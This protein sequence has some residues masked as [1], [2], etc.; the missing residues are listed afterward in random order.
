MKIFVDTAS[1]DE[2]K[3]AASWGVLD[4]VTTNPSLVAK[5]GVDFK[6]RVL[7]I[8]DIVDGPVSAEVTEL[9]ADKM[10]SQGHEI[11]E[12]H[13][14]IVVKIPLIKEGL[15]AI[16]ALSDDGI[17]VNVTL[18]FSVNQALLAAK[19]GATFVSVF[20]GRVDDIGGTGMD[21]ISDCVE[22]FNIYGFES[23]VLAASLRHPLHI[24]QAAMAGADIVTVP[25]KVLNG[26]FDHPLTDSGNERFLA[27]WKKAQE[28]M[29]SPKE[30]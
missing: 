20:V 12:W 1:L 14:N 17:K 8:C 25:Y 22:V 15:K 6:K 3:E 21:I 24:T 16:R 29:K 27:D 30:A 18:C 11:A 10:I 7:E 28:M 2:I 23:Q 19:A 5:E 13:P 26:M 9:Q 4:G